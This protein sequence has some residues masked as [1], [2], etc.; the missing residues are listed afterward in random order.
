VSREEEGGRGINVHAV[1]KSFILILITLLSHN[2]PRILAHE[3]K[4]VGGIF[5]KSSVNDET[6][7][8][9]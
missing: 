9:L 7:F 8:G 6:L 5:K 1:L 4:P 2:V 3:T